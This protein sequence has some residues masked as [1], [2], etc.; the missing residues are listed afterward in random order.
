VK[1][2]TVRTARRPRLPAGLTLLELLVTLAILSLVTVILAQALAQSRR[3]EAQLDS[4][5]LQAR[6]ATVRA[7]WL[8]ATLESVIAM[9]EGSADVFRGEARTVQGL[10]GQVPGWPLSA[11]SPFS[12]ELTQAAAGGEHELLLWVGRPGERAARARIVIVA[13]RGEPGRME[14]LD[15]AGN[16]RASWPAADAVP[17]RS[18]LPRAIAITTGAAEL[19]VLL[20]SPL[21]SGIPRPTRTQVESL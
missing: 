18:R 14:Y 15:E 2:L 7:A 9:P 21:S 4:V 16:W 12:I 3:V 11:A 19:P 20:A 5:S 1:A 17:G 13:W 8:R 6:T 10:S